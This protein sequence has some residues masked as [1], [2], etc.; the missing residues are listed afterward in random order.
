MRNAPSASRWVIS[1]ACRWIRGEGRT[2]AG[3][4]GAQRR[5]PADVRPTQLRRR[6]Q[7]PVWPCSNRGAR[8]R[9]GRAGP[10]FSTLFFRSSFFG[11]GRRSLLRRT[12]STILQL[13]DVERIQETVRRF[14][15]IG[16]RLMVPETS[17][18]AYGRC[19][20]VGEGQSP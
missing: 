14:G 4:W 17:A 1:P 16:E 7:T 12:V 9:K 2:C 19:G 18:S 8:G 11:S 5:V 10:W 3:R 6:A 13:E 20:S 15:T